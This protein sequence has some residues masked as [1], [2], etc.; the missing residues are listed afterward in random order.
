MIEIPLTKGQV[1]LIDDADFDLVSKHKWHAKTSRNTYYAQ[2]STRLPDGRK[3][4]LKMHRLL[5]GLTDRSVHVDHID[6]NGLNNQRSN[7]RTCTGSENMRNR[8]A[9]SHNKSGF[10]GVTWHKKGGHWR[11]TIR[12]N[13]KYTHLGYFDTPA[14]AHAA[15][16]KA[17]DEL[18]GEFANYGSRNEA[19]RWSKPSFEYITWGSGHPSC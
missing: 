13:G 4:K 15:Y 17:A 3:G 8:G 5:L 1:A 2:T 11:A 6:G 9:A 14:E 19:K 12:L 16:C 18:H 10:K 7:L